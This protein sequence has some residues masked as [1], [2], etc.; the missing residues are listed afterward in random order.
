MN[1]DVCIALTKDFARKGSFLTQQFASAPVCLLAAKTTKYLT[2]CYVPAFRY[3][4]VVPS[5]LQPLISLYNY[6][7]VRILIQKPGS[8]S[9][10]LSR[11]VIANIS[12]NALAATILLTKKTVRAALKIPRTG[13]NVN[14]RNR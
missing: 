2:I 7:S 11:Y 12:L 5:K 9:Q 1:V 3:L 13:E 14:S 10:L 6:T 4:R 8:N